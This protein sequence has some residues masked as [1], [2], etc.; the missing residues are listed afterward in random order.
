MKPISGQKL[1]FQL[2]VFIMVIS[3][4]LVSGA[5]YFFQQQKQRIQREKYNELHAIGRLKSEQLTQWLKERFS[6]ASFFT[7]NQPYGH[8]IAGIL[9]DNVEAERL[10]HGALSGIMTDKRYANIIIVNDKQELVFSFNPASEIDPITIE[11]AASVF[12]SGRITIRDFYYCNTHERIHMEIIAPVV[13]KGT[14]IIAAVIFQID[15]NTYMYPLITTWP[16]L[17]Q[18]AESYLVKKQGDRVYFLNKLR[19]V[20]NSRLDLSISAD[21]TEVT[22][23]KA[24][25]GYEGIVEGKD[26]RGKRV[27]ADIRR[28]DTTSWYIVTEI[29]EEEL[30]QELKRHALWIM[31]V[32][33]LG[34]M[35]IVA[36]VIWFYQLR[37]RKFYKELLQQ[38]SALFQAQEIFSAIFYSIGDGVISTDQYGIVK[39]LNPVAEK[40]TGWTEKEAKGKNIEEVFH[41]VHED[42]GLK[43]E[44]PVEKVIRDGKKIVWA[45]QTLLIAK[46]GEETPIHESCAPVRDSHGNILGVII[47]FNDQTEERIKHKLINIRLKFFEFSFDYP[48]DQALVRM[49]DETGVIFKSPIG[50]IYFLEP[51]QE[52]LMLKSWSSRTQTEFPTDDENHYYF[53]LDDSGVLAEAVRKKK[54]AI[55]ND[56]T[57]HSS[58][59]KM[60]GIQ[61]EFN[62]LMVV[63]VVHQNEVVAVFGIG[64]K[65]AVYTDDEAENLSFLA[66]VAREVVDYK[67]SEIYLRQSEERF[68]N[69]FERAPLGYQSLDENGKFLEV[70]Q[71]WSETL[72]YNK[73]EV[74]GRWFG[75][76]LLPE[77][78][79]IFREKFSDFRKDGKVQAE[80]YMKHQDGSARLIAIKGRIGYTDHGQMKKTHCI[81]QDIT[82][83]RQT[84]EKLKDREK[85]LQSIFR[86]APTGI[87][88][89]KDRVL[90]EVNPRICEISG[91][92][93]SELIGRETS[94]L[95]PGKE[96]FDYV[97]KEKYEQIAR[98]GTGVVET[99][100]KRKDG[101]IID[102]L[103]ASTPIDT[104]DPSTGISF[105]V[106]DITERKKNET[107]IRERERELRSLISNLP[108]FVYRCKYDKDWTMLFLSDN[109]RSVTGY[110]PD[111]FIH[112]KKLSFNQIIKK[113][114]H[115]R[116]FQMWEE[117]ISQKS[118]FR[119]E[120]ELETASGETLWILERGVGVYDDHGNLLFLEGYIEDISER[121]LTE[122]QLMES[123]EKFR[124]IF[125]EHAA[126]KLIIDPENGKIVDANEAAAVFYGWS[127][128]E[129][130]NMDMSQIN[131]LPPDEVN[132][133][134]Q[135]ARDMEN[136]RFEFQHRKANGEVVD[137][138]NFNS[139]VIIGGKIFLHAIIH[140]FSERKKIEI[141]L[142][143]S[144]EHN[145]LI[146][147]NS[148]DAILL[149]KPD[150]Q[151]LSANQAAC[152]MFKMS[153]EEICSLGRTGVVDLEDPRLLVL[154]K[155]REMHGF[156]NGELTYVR[157]DGSKFPAEITSALFENSQ[158]EVFTSMIIRDISERKNWENELIQ[159]KEKAE[160]NDKLKS[161]F[162][163]NMSH[164]IR[165]PM[166]SIIGFLDLLNMPDLEDE[167]RQEY[168]TLVNKSGQRLLGTINDIIEISKIEAG[169]QD[170]TYSVIHVS[171]ILQLYYQIFKPQA[172]EKGIELLLSEKIPDDKK[173]LKTDKNKFEG[174]LINLIKNAIKFTDKGTIRIGNYAEDDQLVFFVQDTGCGIPADKIHSVFDRFIQADMGLSRAYE[175]SGLGLSIINAYT[176][177]LGGRIWVDSEVGKGS[178]FYFSLPDIS[179]KIRAVPMEKEKVNKQI[180]LKDKVV[181]VAE[182]DE[183]S[184]QYLDVVLKREKIMIIHAANGKEA[185]EAFR[186]DR[187]ISIILMDLKM[188]VMDGFEA[189]RA[190][191]LLNKTIPIIAQTAYAFSGDKERAIEAGCN[192]YIA[193][194]IKAEELIDMIRK[195]VR[196]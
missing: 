66:D 156:V 91:Y 62:R 159:A 31:I 56:C 173:L 5:F 67:L 106:L 50:F 79:E 151:I 176:D 143:R 78:I 177:Q 65:P 12:R 36:I 6:E 51:G 174:I 74:T 135:A 58:Q 81:I 52:K 190:I 117:V 84:E 184:Y 194:P 146:M 158:G 87:G 10:Y 26:Y 75:E 104:S 183:I 29:S 13:D 141:A 129:L 47:V 16:T 49:L 15:P 179:G 71:A 181:L 53:A 83:S 64:N 42:T 140:D 178:T 110:S 114:Y 27:L 149:T 20:D 97:G 152:T 88:V 33:A 118:T 46:R 72:G 153:E 8:Y 111:D 90:V 103:L 112:N 142:R 120:Y 11:N 195:Y 41:I 126:V 125:H 94:F 182:D 93:A 123:E 172:E 115:A 155:E 32:I 144:E 102:V 154:L 98:N 4:I 169:I 60:P 128:E 17:T 24:I 23:V 18:T 121:K 1:K 122:I 147:D 39:H 19:H 191:R 148:M 92:D 86:V 89:V 61:D 99:R 21:S 109:C 157:K 165:T 107:M 57:I 187:D 138:E 196:E 100:W 124:N 170:I 76:F 44:N 116:I 160:I 63:P 85:K 37:Q 105:T 127:I 30:Y 3:L 163:T 82:E 70:N 186:S 73:E 167:T 55:Y 175:G 45:N 192:D 14:D 166:N 9:S 189:T 38:R 137:I 77:E 130:T 108:G 80:M 59:M 188:P 113:E 43:Q 133:Y 7:S 139:E 162:L 134:I 145:R 136:A 96:D 171:E 132:S 48:L 164:E 168:I 28:V 35:F 131:I 150:G 95:Y 119:F 22:A 161:A 40:L 54:Y 69:L 68:Y 2:S 185:V 25:Q 101:E 180:A 34:I 193:K